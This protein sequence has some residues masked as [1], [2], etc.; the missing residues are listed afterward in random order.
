M[1]SRFDISVLESKD[2]RHGLDRNTCKC[3]GMLMKEL[4]E[5]QSLS[6]TGHQ[7]AQD[8]RNRPWHIV[9]MAKNL[10]SVPRPQILP[11]FGRICTHTIHQPLGVIVQCNLPRFML[12]W[13][14]SVVSICTH[15]HCIRS[16]SLGTP[17]QCGHDS[18]GPS[19]PGTDIVSLEVCCATDTSLTNSLNSETRVSQVRR[20]PWLVRT[21]EKPPHSKYRQP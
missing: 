3:V 18:N 12:V 20:D 19:D 8:D 15:V 4:G 14:A 2:R 9:S 7:R 1:V 11:D 10:S 17:K 6:C 16:T 21:Q 13:P 5:K